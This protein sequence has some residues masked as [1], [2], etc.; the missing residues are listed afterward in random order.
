MTF[1]CDVHGLGSWELRG[2]LTHL[3]NLEKKRTNMAERH[4]RNKEKDGFSFLAKHDD[5]ECSFDPPTR[6]KNRDRGGTKTKNIGFLSGY[7]GVYTQRQAQRVGRWVGER[8]RWIEECGYEGH[9]TEME[10][11]PGEVVQRNTV[12][13][14]GFWAGT[15]NE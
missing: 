11:C 4:K 6:A 5:R 7:G 1:C 3:C 2:A 8:G 15:M 14:L 13:I 9:V 12:S 10:R